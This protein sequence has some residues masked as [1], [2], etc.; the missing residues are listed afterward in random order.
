M[1]PLVVVVVYKCLDAAVQVMSITTR[2]KIHV[3]MF[4]GPEKP[5][6]WPI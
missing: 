1:L 2:L 6:K 5:L 4:Q 3:F